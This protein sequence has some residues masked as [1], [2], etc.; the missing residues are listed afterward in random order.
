MD[1]VYLIE[2]FRN[3]IQFQVQSKINNKRIAKKE[4]GYSTEIFASFNN[5]RCFAD[6]KSRISGIK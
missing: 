1:I 2:V 4:K 3:Y 6:K 5:H